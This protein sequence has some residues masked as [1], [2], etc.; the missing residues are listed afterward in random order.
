MTLD[1]LDNDQTQV[2]GAVCFT[3]T[4]YSSLDK[5]IFVCSSVSYSPRIVACT[6]LSPSSPSPLQ[7]QPGPS[8][9]NS[10]MANTGICQQNY[11]AA[12]TPTMAALSASHLTLLFYNIL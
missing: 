4:A 5:S 6:V 3:H 11:R 10:G 8:V 12:A 7:Q 2:G 1:C 9:H